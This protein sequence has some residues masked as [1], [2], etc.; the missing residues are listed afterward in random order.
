[1]SNINE[2]AQSN[3]QQHQKAVV[4]NIR[5]LT[6]YRREAHIEL[7]LKQFECL[8]PRMI[9]LKL[10]SDSVSVSNEAYVALIRTLILRDDR[11]T[12]WEIV[13]LL[14]KK[15]ANRTYKHLSVWGY[16]KGEKRED[17]TSEI[18]RM[19]I[20]AVTSLDPQQEFWE[21]RFWV[22]F[23]RRVRTLLRDM[24]TNTGNDIYT[25][26]IEAFSN[27]EYASQGPE[28]AEMAAAKEA[29]SLLPE[30]FRT[31]FYLKHYCGFKEESYK[32]SEP[33]IADTLKVSGRT[34]RNYLRRAEEILQE[35]RNKD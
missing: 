19:M 34:V 1:M 17:A 27:N 2:Y 15:V 22:C 3:N 7:E 8:S 21:C 29:L 28:W 9:L 5:P 10:Q 35:W 33:T 31:A 20:E 24:Q 14:V 23:D 32:T 18:V 26:D 6:L 12:A 16:I 25:D 30:P 4:V 11:K 13:K